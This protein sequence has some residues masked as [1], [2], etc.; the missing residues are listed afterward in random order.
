MSDQTG[1]GSLT[2]LPVIECAPTGRSMIQTMVGG[3]VAGRYYQT[4]TRSNPK[5]QSARRIRRA[6]IHEVQKP[7][8]KPSSLVLNLVQ[9]V[10][11][12]SSKYD[13]SSGY[14]HIPYPRIHSGS[15][16]LTRQGRLL[17][18]SGVVTDI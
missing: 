10:N 8:N 16:H 2:A 18:P 9:W 7:I 17:R 13:E 15:A 4:T 14:K 1:A 3:E 5:D 11:A 6:D 12:A